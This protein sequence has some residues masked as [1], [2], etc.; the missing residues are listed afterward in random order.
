[1]EKIELNKELFEFYEG[2]YKG[3]WGKMIRVI[4]VIGWIISNNS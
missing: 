2:E 4:G 3:N 1:M